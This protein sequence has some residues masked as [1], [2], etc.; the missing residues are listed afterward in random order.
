MVKVLLRYRKVIAI[1][2]AGIL[3]MLGIV[4]AQ[5]AS[6]TPQSYTFSGYDLTQV[7]PWSNSSSRCGSPC[8][9]PVVTA[10]S[11][12]ATTMNASGVMVHY[13]TPDVTGQQVLNPPMAPAVGQAVGVICWTTS[14]NWGVVDKIDA[15]FQ[16]TST[17]G[18]NP[19]IPAG[20]Y[21]FIGYVDDDWV[22]L[23]YSDRINYVPSCWRRRLRRQ[24]NDVNTTGRTRLGRIDQGSRSP[25]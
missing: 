6:A 14:S 24:K 13:W 21:L 20:S 15:R 4:T 18:L 25:G 19:N 12:F 9:V 1:I 2:V 5:A 7:T 3:M 11:H 16:V 23:S 22:N 17:S 10:T 8:H